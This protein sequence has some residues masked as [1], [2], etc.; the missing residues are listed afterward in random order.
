MRTGHLGEPP[1]AVD[2][3]AWLAFACLHAVFFYLD[4][5][6]SP[7]IPL[8]DEV[9]YRTLAESAAQG[10]PAVLEPLWPP[11]YVWMLTP[12]ARFGEGWP[13]LLA[14]VQV[15]LLAV[16]ALL[17]RRVLEEVTGSPRAARVGFV[18][19]L[20]DPHLAGFAH[21]AWPEVPH[22][23]LL[24]LL[25]WLVVRRPG[26]HA[27]WL[28]S[29]VT[30]AAIGLTKSV[31]VPYLPLLA[32][33]LA[34]EIG[35]RSA[36]PRAGGVAVLAG[37]LMLPTALGNHR[38]HGA[39][40]VADSSLFNAWLGLTADGRRSAAHDHAAA[41]MQVY[42]SGGD[43]FAAR[44][45]VL[46]ARLAAFV[47]ERGVSAIIRRQWP[48]QYFRLFDYRTFVT[49]QLAGGVFNVRRVGYVRP[50]AGLSRLLQAWNVVF[51]AAVL[52]AAGVGMW[53]ASHARPWV[54]FLV[55]TLGYALVIFLV[56]ESRSRFR[57]PL[58]LPLWTAA[59]IVF[60]RHPLTRQPVRWAAGLGTSA[61][62]TAFAFGA[63][64][65]P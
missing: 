49:E 55:G 17:F 20:I 48:R 64:Y 41:A 16:A 23:A 15:V 1:P 57:I 63:D 38:T 44:Q 54:L 7:R 22:V 60:A 53:T 33:P 24:V 21:Y 6:P 9:M 56:L 36:M 19:M 30:I 37:L 58:M 61:V 59:A 50:P 40:V 28:A 52:G 42:H 47:R 51:Y 11:L 65:L 8:G 25:L 39:F 35:W 2:W 26:R 43:T 12:L 62:L 46:A 10:A 14:L 4:I 31:L 29:G 32:L 5:V 13:H 45:R 34:H 27:W 3:P 18:L